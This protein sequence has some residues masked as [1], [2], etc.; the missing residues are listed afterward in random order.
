CSCDDWL[1]PCAHVAAACYQLASMLDAD[2]FELL[3]LRGR[4][5]EPL[6]DALRRRRP[7]PSAPSRSQLRTDAA[8]TSLPVDATRFWATAAPTAGARWRARQLA[9]SAPATGSG[10]G[11]D[12]GTGTD[13]D[14]RPDDLL[15]RCGPL[16]VDG[17]GD[18]RALLRPAYRAFTS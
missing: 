9:A 15:D 16:V 18:V 2:P 1:Q 5:R 12:S 11:K 10:S 7:D 17:S 8:S 3:A 6:L 14:E 13:G 4:E